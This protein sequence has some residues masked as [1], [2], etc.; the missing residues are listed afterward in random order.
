[1]RPITNPTAK[2][3]E[4]I[5]DNFKKDKAFSGIDAFSQRSLDCWFKI[6]EFEFD[7]RLTRS[8]FDRI[9]RDIRRK[10]VG[11]Q[12]TFQFDALTNGGAQ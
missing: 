3:I 8:F 10:Y 4:L 5:I 2:R 7:R 12:L 1:M 11:D 9:M 6:L